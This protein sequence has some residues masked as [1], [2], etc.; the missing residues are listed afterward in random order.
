MSARRDGDSVADL[1]DRPVVRTLITFNGGGAWQGIKAPAR[2]ASP[3]C[4]RC[5]GKPDCYLH[6]HGASSWFFGTVQYPSVYSH[7]AAPGLL[8]GT[9]NVAPEGEGL[10][11]GGDGCALRVCV[12]CL[13]FC[14]QNFGIALSYHQPHSVTLTPTTTNTNTN[15]ITARARGSRSTAASRGPTLL[16]AP[17]STST[18]TG[19]A[20]W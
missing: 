6:L 12:G 11:D 2:F 20:S 1:P 14:R 5:G 10:Q 9:G 16:K 3:K 13:C 19:A 7:P 8:V 4:D 15:P 18:P 17:S